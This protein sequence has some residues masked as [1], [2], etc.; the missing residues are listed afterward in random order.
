MFGESVVLV[1]RTGVQVNFPEH[2][3]EAIYCFLG[4]AS[5]LGE[6][7]GLADA[8]RGLSSAERTQR[9]LSLRRPGRWAALCR[10]IERALVRTGL[11]IRRVDDP[12]VPYWDFVP[13]VPDER[14]IQQFERAWYAVPTETPPPPESS[15]PIHPSSHPAATVV[16]DVQ[17]QSSFAAQP[18]VPGRL[19]KP[20]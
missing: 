15:R 9:G 5:R 20:S 17:A 16:W 10:R 8:D 3:R 1:D 7:W 14:E 12:M 11:V 13:H 6:V 4:F 19:L 18:A 2:N